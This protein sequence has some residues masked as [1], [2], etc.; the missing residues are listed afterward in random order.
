[1]PR[2]VSPTPSCVRQLRALQEQEFEPVGGVTESV[3]VRVV[4]ATNRDLEVEMEDVRKFQQKFG[5]LNHDTPTHLTRRKL[6]ERYDF[7]LEELN[8][9]ADGVYN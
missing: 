6:K 3:E 4:A 2:D 8:E 5:H 7:M 1:M 9:F